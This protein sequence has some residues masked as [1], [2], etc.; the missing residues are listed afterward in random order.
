MKNLFNTKTILYFLFLVAFWGCQTTDIAPAINGLLIDNNDLIQVTN[1]SPTIPVTISAKGSSLNNVTV[2]IT[3]EGATSPIATNSLKNITS[4]NLGQFIMNIPFPLPALAPSG[5]Y[6]VD[7]SI[8]NGAIKGTSYSVNILNYQVKTLSACVFPQQIL[9]SGKT[10][11]LQVTGPENTNGDDLYV[12]GDFEGWSGGGNTAYKLTKVAGS[13]YCYYIALN[14]GNTNEFKI[15]RGAWG[16]ENAKADG[17]GAP[18]YK[19][20]SQS[21]QAITVENWADR[22]V[23]PTPTLPSDAL[24][25]GKITVVANVGG[26]VDDKFKF[27]LVKQGT[28]SLTGAIE[29]IRVAGTTKVAAAVAKEAGAKYVVVKEVITKTGI[30]TFGFDKI[31]TIDGV[32]NPV[33]VLIGG[34][35][36]EFT[37]SPV[38]SALFMVGDATAGGWNNPVPVPS[39]QF[40]STTNGIYTLT[41]ALTT[42]KEYLMLPVNGSWDAKFGMGGQDP[43]TGDLIPGGNNFKA[44]TVTGNYKVTADFTLGIYTLVKQ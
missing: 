31:A 40:T 12:S 13:T 36:T 21:V 32:T 25:S 17:G 27:Y 30:N 9:P 28:T 29:L 22:I 43:L 15:T 18:N 2:A 4:N 37:P 41:I 7:Y 34:F 39:Q 35:K 19:W 38:P 42:G 14:L 23:L 24:V 44:P 1:S 6:I 10:V 3:K 20:N 11:W 33:N 5:K 16:K 26:S 8:N